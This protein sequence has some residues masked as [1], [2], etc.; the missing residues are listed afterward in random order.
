MESKAK[1]KTSSKFPLVVAMM[2]L[3]VCMTGPATAF[4]PV[5]NHKLSLYEGENPE[6]HGNEFWYHH[7]DSPS[8]PEGTD[9]EGTENYRTYFQIDD[10]SRRGLDGLPTNFRSSSGPRTLYL[11][12]AYYEM[13]VSLDLLR[14]RAAWWERESF[15]SPER[16]F[17]AKD[18]A[19]FAYYDPGWSTSGQRNWPFGWSV[20]SREL[21]T[22]HSNDPQWSPMSLTHIFPSYPS[23]SDKSLHMLVVGLDNSGTRS[24]MLLAT[25]DPY[26]SQNMWHGGLG[27]AKIWMGEPAGVDTARVRDNIATWVEYNEEYPNRSRV[28][29]AVYVTGTS[30]HGWDVGYSRWS[31]RP[32][33]EL[34]IGPDVIN[35]IQ[36]PDLTIGWKDS[37]G[38]VYIRGYDPEQEMSGRRKGWYSGPTK[39]LA[40]FY[41][42]YYPQTPPETVYL[43]DMSIGTRA[44]VPATYH[45]DLGGIPGYDYSK[46]CGTDQPFYCD[47][48]GDGPDEWPSG[49]VVYEREGRYVI[50]LQVCLNGFVDEYEREI[51]V[52]P[53]PR[54]PIGIPFP[55]PDK[56]IGRPRPPYVPPGLIVMGDIQGDTVNSANV[57]LHASYGATC[58]GAGIDL[59][60][61][62]EVEVPAEV[63]YDESTHFISVTPT[64]GFQPNTTYSISVS[65]GVL[66]EDGTP[67]EG[68]SWSFYTK[69]DLKI[70]KQATDETPIKL[71]DAVVSAAF[72]DEEGAPAGF[73]IQETDRSSGIRVI[74]SSKVLPGDSV[75]VEGTATVVDG[76]RVILADTVEV[77]FAGNDLPKPIFMNNLTTGGGICGAQEPV[78]DD[79][80]GSFPKLASGLNNVGLLVSIKG[81]V[82][83]AVDTGG[84][85]G[86]FYVD[87]GYAIPDG[88]QTGLK[89][90]SGNIGIR[91]S[92]IPIG[93]GDDGYM[94]AEVPQAGDYVVAAGVVG[95]CQ[96]NGLNV[97][98]FRTQ[99]LRRIAMPPPEP[100][101]P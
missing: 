99:S 21:R 7:W 93:Y 14:D 41:F 87:D 57:T 85:D 58:S 100:E 86:Y 97:R 25:H 8:I 101:E 80:T 55:E 48:H 51:G 22:W 90:G 39:P 27:T 89:D 33:T 75:N 69:D 24:R 66:Y 34:V 15:T 60:N 5:L 92:P 32:V 1:A 28:C 71:Y 40:F 76:E 94:L 43:T 50:K 62:P 19:Y 73:A 38:Q 46:V 47:C 61:E 98:H 84:F 95:V 96:I 67:F 35:G 49:L 36:I 63:S 82:T 13:D 78:V 65:D 2:W 68:Y 44:S 42:N 6:P 37:D 77:T 54:P 81:M 72:Y 17:V 3:L 18:V 30:A 64:E 29:Y 45:W 31:P 26:L 74:S 83:A 20:V 11:H 56:P 9:P 16:T 4:W 53:Y 70:A 79:A 23:E 88:D 12:S 52:G 10:C 91:C 59:E